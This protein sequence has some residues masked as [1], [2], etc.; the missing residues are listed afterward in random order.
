MVFISL[1]IKK[2]VIKLKSSMMENIFEPRQN[3]VGY[4]KAGSQARENKYFVVA[5]FCLSTAQ[6]AFKK[7][8]KRNH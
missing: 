3:H 8:V 5:G 7:E 1:D 6:K 4:H 2:H